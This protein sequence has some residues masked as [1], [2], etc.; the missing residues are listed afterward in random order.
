MA[1]EMPIPIP[2]RTRPIIIVC[3][4]RDVALQ[5]SSNQLEIKPCKQVNP[6]WTALHF[7]GCITNQRKAPTASGIALS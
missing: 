2:A 4:L 5:Q 1:D 3:T 7:G 6:T